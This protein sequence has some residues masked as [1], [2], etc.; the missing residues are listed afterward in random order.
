MPQA[1][2]TQLLNLARAKEIV[3]NLDESQTAVMLRKALW[4]TTKSVTGQDHKDRS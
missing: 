1:T 3:D 4:A 2:T